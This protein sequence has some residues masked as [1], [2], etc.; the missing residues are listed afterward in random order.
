GV[1]YPSGWH[2]SPWVMRV[3]LIV[4]SVL[5]LGAGLFAFAPSFASLLP[6]PNIP[7]TYGVT[8]ALLSGISVGLG[9]LGI[10][11]AYAMWGNGRMFTLPA[12]SPVQPLRRL[13]LNRYYFKAGYDWIGLKGIYSIAR[14]TDFIDQYVIDG[15]IRGIERVF[16]W[17]SQSLR[18]IQSGVVSDYAGYVVAGL[19]GFLLLLLFVAPTII[20]WG[21]G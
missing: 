5:A 11:L 15:A 18:R 17:M 12:E 16:A 10:G 6:G 1:S 13:L 14:A 8:D 3:P 7:P 21:G 4:L 19:V 2:D 9:F 20:Q